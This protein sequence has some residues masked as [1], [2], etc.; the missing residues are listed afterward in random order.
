M[1]T[2]RPA[3]LEFGHIDV[4]KGIHR[5]KMRLGHQEN[6]DSV[7]EATGLQQDWGWPTVSSQVAQIYAA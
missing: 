7:M 2:Q 4:S 5:R 3:Y 1:V 6:G